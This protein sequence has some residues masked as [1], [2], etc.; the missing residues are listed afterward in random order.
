MQEGVA[1]RLRWLEAEAGKG[2][3]ASAVWEGRL[4]QQQ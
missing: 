2:E 1:E 4:E 3:G